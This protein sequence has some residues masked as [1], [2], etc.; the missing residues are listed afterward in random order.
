M[1]YVTLKKAL[2][3]TLQAVLLFWRLLSDILIENSFKL[4]AIQW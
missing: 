2:Y 4:N 3:G 1:V